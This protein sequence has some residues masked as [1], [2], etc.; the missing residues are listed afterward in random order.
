MKKL[1]YFFL[2]S[3]LIFSACDKK[4]DDHKEAPVP[5][6]T[7]LFHM[8]SYIGENEVEDYGFSYSTESGRA[9]SLSLGQ[10]YIS[11]I[12]VVKLDGSVYA[13][14]DTVLL[15][16][17][18]TETYAAGKIPVGNYKG[19]R[20]KIGLKT[21]TNALNPSAS[22]DSLALSH[23]EMWFGNT[24]QPDGYA[25]LVVK[26]SI[27]T[28]SDNSGDMQPFSYKI[29][30][31]ENY[32]QVTLPEQNFTILENQAEYAHLGVD[33]S[34]LFSGVQ[35]NQ[36]SNLSVE[37]ADNSSVLAKKITANIPLMFKYD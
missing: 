22:K 23:S 33:F 16:T 27:D 4:D 37:K 9:V 19:L 15:K 11:D 25:Y 34:K 21:A 6:G 30:T 35:L 20:F 1:F 7:L 32:V 10:F 14:S 12:E 13:L 26:G 2:F 17:L 36:S 31:N 18:D 28:T 24:A 3:L 29:G 5:T 8:H